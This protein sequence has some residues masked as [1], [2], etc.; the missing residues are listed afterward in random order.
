M[1]KPNCYDCIHRRSLAGDAHSACHHPAFEKVHDEPLLK[2]AALF[3]SVQR[4]PP[5]QFKSKACVVV[6]SEHGIRSGW[7][8]HPLNFD[9]VW[10]ESCNGF[11]SEKGTHENEAKGNGEIEANEVR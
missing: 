10:L 11:E 3:A 8:N 6:G 9:P 4:Q 5:F 1:N 2:I 7:F